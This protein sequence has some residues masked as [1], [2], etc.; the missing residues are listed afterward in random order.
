MKWKCPVCNQSFLGD[1]EEV[2]EAWS[3]HM[4]EKKH[5]KDSR[6]WLGKA[7]K[8]RPMLIRGVTS[9]ELKSTSST[10]MKDACAKLLFDRLRK[11]EDEWF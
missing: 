8:K 2:R 9:E 11:P 1:E 4:A 10:F 5:L 7:L 3:K 6:E